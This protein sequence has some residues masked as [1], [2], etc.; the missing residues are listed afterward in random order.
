MEKFKIKT[1]HDIAKFFMWLVFDKKLAFHPDDD[2]QDYISFKTKERTFTDKEAD[3]Y[4]DLM[5][6]CFQ[7]CESADCD[8][9]EIANNVFNLYNACTKD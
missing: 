7:I 4:N 2:F 8:I 3:Y 9:Y 5:D 1:T 6:K